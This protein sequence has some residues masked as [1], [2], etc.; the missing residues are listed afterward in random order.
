MKP[1]T[2]LNL[3][4]ANKNPHPRDKNL[5]FHEPTHKYTITT[6]PNSKYISVTTF[7]HHHF[8]QFNADEIIKKMMNGRNWNTANKYWGKTPEEIKNEWNKNATLVSGQGTNMHYDIECFMNQE[9]L[10][11]E[12]NEPIS[13]THA[14]LLEIYL[15][16]I[17]QGIIQ[18][19]TSI[20]WGYFLQFIQAFPH[21]KPYRTEWTIYNEDIKMAGSID[22]VYENPDGTLSIYDW[23]RVKEITKSNSFKQYAIEECIDYLPDTNFWHYS[24]QLNTYKALL[25]AKYDKK[26]TSLY[27]VKLHP[28]NIS[29][30]FELIKCAD[31][32]NEVKD[33][34]N[35]RKKN[36]SALL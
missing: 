13:Y 12:T 30:T 32:T 24:L 14:D 17:N 18:P 4:L 6:D 2:E 3:I 29:K 22:M 11:A 34:F 33:L 20:E 31:L 15:D 28:C 7:N 10:D 35:I 23:K 19:N 27:L 5:V 8:P 16:E 9:L 21:L 36:I 26:I 25:E 1:T